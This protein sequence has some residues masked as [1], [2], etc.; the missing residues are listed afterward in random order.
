M[1][2]KSNRI[3]F[4]NYSMWTKKRQRYDWYAW[5]VFVA[6]PRDVL[7]NIERVEYQL[8]PTFPDPLRIVTDRTHRFA[9]YSSGWGEFRIAVRVVLED[10]TDIRT[11]YY[12]KLADDDWPK[13]EPSDTF[14]DSDVQ[15]VYSELSGSKF[16]WRK[17]PTIVKR[18]GLRVTRV[19]KIL[20]GLEAQG[21]ARQRPE[22]SIDNEILWSATSIVGVAPE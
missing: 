7:Q 9:L 16:R 11:G 8:H 2:K 5:C 21:L 6:E 3:Q 14:S 18:T 1:P 13:K 10:D 17:L 15:N 22:R 20:A 12:L 4:K 19:E